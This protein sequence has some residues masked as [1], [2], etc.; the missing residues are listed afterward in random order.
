MSN[1]FPWTEKYRPTVLND[2]ILD[3]DNETILNNI[4]K[5][6]KFPNLLLYGPPGTGKTTTII[7]L[8]NKYQK[9]NNQNYKSLIIHLNASDDRGIDI[10]RNNLNTFVNSNNL[11]KIGTKFIILDE[12]DYMTKS[13]QIALKYLIKSNNNTNVRFCLICNYIS[14][15]ELSLQYLFC[16]IKFINL[17]HDLI[18]KYINNI[19]EK[20]NIN[21]QK[22][23][24]VSLINYYKFDVRSMINYLQSNKNNL[25]SFIPEYEFNNL[26]NNHI[27]SDNYNNFLKLINK[28]EIDYS[29]N[30][31]NILKNYIKYIFDIKL[32]DLILKNISK[33]EFIIH[34]I[35]IK[36]IN[37]IIISLYYILH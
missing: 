19:V 28:F 6:N 16:K 31:L 35:N 11:F 9:I 10:I 3:K 15:I 20:E 12:V 13:A 32:D 23:Y 18:L 17:P 26:Y 1:N 36:N 30:K 7:N 34:N 2:I 29:T 33:F 5:T 24:I 25:I 37:Y 8:I 27:K 21:I 14:K 4:L 22:D